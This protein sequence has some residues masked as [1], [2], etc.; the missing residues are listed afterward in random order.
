MIIHQSI[1]HRSSTNSKHDQP[2]LNVQMYREHYWKGTWRWSEGG[3]LVTL[4]CAPGCVFSSTNSTHDELIINIQ[5]HGELYRKWLSII[6]IMSMMMI[7]LV[8]TFMTKMMTEM[9]HLFGSIL[10]HPF[11]ACPIVKV[12][13]L[14]MGVFGRKTR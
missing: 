3:W 11:G 13:S 9:D 2:I 7:M 4:R 5:I 1:I 8:I 10:D 12:L 14:N 6:Y